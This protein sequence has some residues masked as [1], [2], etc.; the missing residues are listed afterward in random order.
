MGLL[1]AGLEP[2]TAQ[3]SLSLCPAVLYGDDSLLGLGQI[4]SEHKRHA[5]YL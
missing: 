2:A 3:I 5:F 1:G 4:T